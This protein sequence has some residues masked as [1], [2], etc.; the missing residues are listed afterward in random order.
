VRLGY[1][2]SLTAVDGTS[3]PP[4]LALEGNYPNPFNPQTVIRFAV[5][6]PQ[7]VDLGVF[8]LHGRRVVTLVSG[9]LPAGQHA[10]T[11]TG[12][13]GQGRLVGSGLYVYR[14][15]AAGRILTNK[16]LLLK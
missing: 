3:P 2:S 5:P 4:L 11:W 6:S 13:D 15:A 7:Q 12:R 16:M 8:D 1:P 10:V 9:M 14:L